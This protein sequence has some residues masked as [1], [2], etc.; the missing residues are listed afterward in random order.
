MLSDLTAI[1]TQGH[2]GLASNRIVAIATQGHFGTFASSD[3][4][5]LTINVASC[6][7]GITLS[8]RSGG[9]VIDS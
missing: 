6:K 1:A 7:G 4:L 2:F 3:V 5:S 9:I 8:R